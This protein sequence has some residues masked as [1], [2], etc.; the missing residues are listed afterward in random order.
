MAKK[1]WIAGEMVWRDDPVW[2]P[3]EG[4]VGSLAGWFMWM[5]EIRLDG[6]IAVQAYKHH[7]TRSYIHLDAERRAYRYERRRER[8][9]YRQINLAHALIGAFAGWQRLGDSPSA[10][11]HAL[12]AAV[13]DLS[14]T[15]PYATGPDSLEE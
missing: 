8:S 15:P 1:M 11:E 13:I 3:L 7:A 12:V 14:F 6:G 9:M 4:V 5:G 10:E 2:A